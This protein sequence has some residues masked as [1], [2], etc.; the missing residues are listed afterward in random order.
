MTQK[1]TRTEQKMLLSLAREAITGYVNGGEIPDSE[2]PT[3]EEE[4]DDS[5]ALDI[6]LDR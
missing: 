4:I 1:L 2:V 3:M 6:I 5:E